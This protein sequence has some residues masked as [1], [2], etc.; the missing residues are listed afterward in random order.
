MSQLRLHVNGPRVDGE[1]EVRREDALLALGLDPQLTGEPARRVL[2]DDGGLL[3]AYVIQRIALSA[4]GVACPVAVAA[5]PMVWQPD[6]SLGV[7]QLT[8][9]CASEPARLAIQCDLLF[10]LD[11]KHRAYFS[12]EDA[13]VTQ[14]GVFRA[15]RRSVLLD[16]HQFHTGAGFV[17]FVREGIAHIWSGLD[18]VL[19]LLALLLPASLVRTGSSWSPRRGLGA[20]AREVVKVVTA[21]TLAH[22]LTLSLA[23]FGLVTLPSRWVEVAIALSVFA[24]AWNNLRPFMPGRGWA[25]ALVFGLVHGLGFAGALRNLA[26]PIHAR[27]LALAAFNV[28]VELGQL[29]IVALVLPVLYAASRQRWYPR[30]VLGVGS[31]V[32]AWL[33]VLWTIERAFGLSLVSWR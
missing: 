11:P 29:L 25:M 5:A 12:V 13:R 19:F 14:V 20:T 7:L 27:A 33:A 6:Q 30:I 21:F 3:R 10:D 24:A 9:T 15:D 28:G 2:R 22:S 18:H 23:F 4:D 8:A 26:V 17:E 16:V 31:L 32:V 1:W